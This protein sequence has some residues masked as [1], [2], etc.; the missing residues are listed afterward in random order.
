MNLNTFA[1]TSKNSYRTGTTACNWSGASCIGSLEVSRSGQL[2]NP[3]RVPGFPLVIGKRLLPARG[4]FTDVIPAKAEADGLTGDRRRDL[5]VKET[6]V[7][8]KCSGKR[9]EIVGIAIVEPTKKPLLTL[10]IKSPNRQP[11]VDLSTW[12]HLPCKKFHLHPAIEILFTSL[13]REKLFP[14]PLFLERIGPSS[15]VNCPG[16]QQK[17][18]ITCASHRFAF[19][20]IKCRR[21][22]TLSRYSPV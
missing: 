18:E 10:F 5:L 20:I 6:N 11:F 9:T 8:L 4:A 15:I 12:E 17:I 21:D 7:V 1:R 14:D 16:S 3:D 2:G 13:R 19:L 22:C